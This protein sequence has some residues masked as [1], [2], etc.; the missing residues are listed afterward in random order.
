MQNE[1]ANISNQ[2]VELGALLEASPVAFTM[3]TLGWKILFGILILV[4]MWFLY[5]YYT[6]Y[7]KKAYKREAVLKIKH[8][9]ELYKS[10]DV[11]LISET[12]FQLKQTA[13]QTYNRTEVASLKGIEWLRFL[14]KK[15]NTT[16]FSKNENIITSALYNNKL[17]E[18]SLFNRSDFVKS[19]I[20]WIKTHA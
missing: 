13:L 11:S 4:T 10:N 5:R 9:A 12:M 16:S 15:G 1:P 7:K 8:L 18:T 17:D 19:S 20:K 2:T 6:A 14:D 3:D